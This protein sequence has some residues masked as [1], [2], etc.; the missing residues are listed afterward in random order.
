MTIEIES[1]QTVKLEVEDDFGITESTINI[2]LLPI[3]I[4][5]E[6]LV[7]TPSLKRTLS[8]ETNISRPDL[9]ASVPHYSTIR[10][11]PFVPK[12]NMPDLKIKPSVIDLSKQIP[13]ESISVKGWN[14]IKDITS[15]LFNILKSSIKLQYENK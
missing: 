14:Y 3:P 15:S 2:R 12:M 5:E 4:M 1:S 10:T 11:I 13:D 8:I 6:I 9:S 7:P